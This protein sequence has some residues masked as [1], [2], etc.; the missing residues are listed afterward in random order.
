MFFTNAGGGSLAGK[1]C[2][3]GA[4]KHRNLT[5]DKAEDVSDR[6]TNYALLKRQGDAYPRDGGRERT[7]DGKR[8]RTDAGKVLIGNIKR[9]NGSF[10]GKSESST[11]WTRVRRC[12][13]L[14]P[15]SL[16]RRNS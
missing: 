14:T 3:E 13:C 15:K 11:D 7:K 4:K 16:D 9:E 1:K 10:D 5:Q 2:Q 6:A 8:S 12:L